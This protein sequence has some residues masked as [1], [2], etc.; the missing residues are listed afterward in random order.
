V[1]VQPTH[2]LFELSSNLECRVVDL[3]LAKRTVIVSKREP[4]INTR[5]MKGVHA[6]QHANLLARAKGSKTDEAF[7]L[8]LARRRR[9]WF[10]R[11]G[12]RLLG[13]LG[14]SINA[15]SSSRSFIMCYVAFF[16]FGIHGSICISAHFCIHRLIRCEKERERERERERELKSA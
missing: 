16:H 8:T 7:P 5:L 2:L 3:L 1:C 11:R 15:S 13:A 10:R 4:L 12:W 6:G 14:C 9:C